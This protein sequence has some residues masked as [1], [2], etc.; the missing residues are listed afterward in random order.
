MS[1]FVLA[2]LAELDLEDIWEFIASDS[3]DDASRFVKSLI[4]RFP[5]LAENPKIGRPRT[6]LRSDLRSHPVAN[7]L[8][9]YRLLPDGVEII[10]VVHAGRNL[11][12]LFRRRQ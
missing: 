1:R 10:R 9:L 6:D 11:V 3:P 12:A 5:L 4:D 2:S 8:I 7:Y